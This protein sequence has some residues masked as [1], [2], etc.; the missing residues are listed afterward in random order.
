MTCNHCEVCSL[1]K[2]KCEKEHICKKKNA[3]EFIDENAIKD[4]KPAKWEADSTF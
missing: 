1:Y 2:G 3:K 4:I